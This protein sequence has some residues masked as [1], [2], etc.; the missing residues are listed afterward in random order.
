MERIL[1][2]IQ[3]LPGFGRMIE[4][5]QGGGACV[6]R[7]P[8]RSGAAAVVAALLGR[9]ERPALAVCPGLEYAEEFA[10]DVNLFQRGLACCFPALE[11]TLGQ[12]EEP[13]EALLSARLAVLRH[14][15]LGPEGQKDDEVEAGQ[16]MAPCWRTRLVSTSINAVLQ[17][18]CSPQQVIRGSRGVRQGQPLEPAALVRWLVQSG[19]HSVPR[20]ELPGQYSM[21]GGIVDVFSHGS[22]RPVRIEFFGDIVDSIRQFDPT[23]QLSRGKVSGCQIMAVENAVDA[24]ASVGGGSLLSFLAD[25]ALVILL[26]PE[27]VQER[28]RELRASGRSGGAFPIAEEML[29]ALCRRAGLSFTQDG[30]GSGEAGGVEIPCRERDA[31]GADLEAMLSELGRICERFA[32]TVVFCINEA[33]RERFERLLQD[34]GFPHLHRMGFSEGR[35][36]HGVLFGDGAV[37]LIPHQRLF[38]RYRQRRVLRH[39]EEGRPIES[40]L[41]LEPGD[42]VVHVEHGIGRF[43]GIRMLE[44]NGQR[45][46]HLEIEFDENARVYVPSDR[47]ELVHRYIGVGGRT[48]SLSRLRSASWRAAKAKAQA[49]VQDMAAELLGLQALRQSSPGIAAPPSGEWER[50]F[51]SEFP[52]EETEDQLQAIEAVKRDMELSRPMDRLVCGDVGY[53]KTEIAMR[54]AFK[55]VMGGRQVAVLVPTTILA[56]QHFMTFRERMADYPIRVEML[57][58][59]LS[60]SETAE[61]LEGMEDGT[62]DIVIGTH[63]LLQRDVGFKDLGLVI[64]DE[65]Q[66]FGVGHKEKLKRLR[67]IVDVLTLTATPIPRTLHMAMM[68]L[69]DISSLQ[70]PPRDR[71]AIE[72]V[73][74]RFDAETLRQAIVRELNREGQVYLVHNRVRSIDALAERVRNLVADARVAVAHGQMPENLLAQTMKRFMEREIDV[75]VSTTII[76]NGLDIPNVNTIIIDR[77]DLLGLAELHQLRGRVG[78]YIR[79]A[80]AYIFTP[81]DRPITPEA[82]KRLDAI[83]RFSR[84]GAGF[85]IALRDM[86][87]RGAGNILGP[88]Q[89]GHIAAVGYNLY[90]RLLER[91]VRGAKGEHVREPP[92]VN[93]SLGLEAYLPDDYVP[94][95]REKIEIYRQLNR[96][97]EPAQ[98]A[99]AGAQMKD[100][101]GPLPQEAQNLLLEAEIRLL[102]AQAGIDSVQLR[103]GRLYFGIRDRERF[104]ARFAEGEAALRLI[105]DHTAV[106]DVRFQRPGPVVAAAVRELL[107]AV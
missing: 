2:Y 76:E 50:R 97:C 70:T 29:D 79:K 87:I 8:V 103:D 106:C 28:A 5:V 20:V 10:E 26:E 104:L 47:I 93:V 11:T 15:A 22:A 92:A 91:A 51:E 86:E 35:L 1:Q 98:V 99:Q 31:F 43:H 44:H 73:V 16:W 48:P 75:L 80:Y 81:R 24:G 49:A 3:E 23:T 25:D 64:I 59:F 66:R 40:A 54:A 14:L 65:E 41:E 53:G 9:T 96:A 95:P 105:E 52:Y 61:V 67:S 21:R 72:T 100:R 89:S 102:A 56:Q 88:Q 57:S 27:A 17:P 45:R 38:H 39:V 85:E 36:N 6:V 37:A 12:D 60:P 71:Q 69:R 30:A 107:K 4:S 101:F 46:E 78:R 84:L 13:D 7:G 18:T 68:G 55:A 77:A 33:E 63:R 62:V 19:F 82:Q 83:K 34:R 32:H 94:T 74:K 58:R 90:C 42:V